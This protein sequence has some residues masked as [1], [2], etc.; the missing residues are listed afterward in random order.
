MRSAAQ[1]FSGVCSD[2]APASH[3]R[4]LRTDIQ[5]LRAISVLAVVLAHAKLPG[6]S[7]G[8]VGVDIF[9][10][11]SGFLITRLLLLEIA[12]TGR[13]D[14][15]RFWVK[16]A[17]R[18]LPNALT[19]LAVTA[20][21]AALVFP[22]Y[23][24]GQL[25]QEITLAAL[26]VVNFYFASTATD[27]FNFDG[28][29]SP[30][31]HFWSLNVE[32]QFYFAWPLILLFI[33]TRFRHKTF[34][35]IA[36]FLITL[37]FV[38]FFASLYI[39]GTDQPRAYFH[40]EMRCWQLAS[41][42]LLAVFS[43][44]I[45]IWPRLLR[46]A[47]AWAGFAAVLFSIASFHEAMTYPG[48]WALVPTLGTV[49]IL[50]GRIGAHSLDDPLQ[51]LFSLP[52]LQWI[53][54]RSYSWYLWHWPLLVLPQAAYP[55]MVYLPALSIL[56]S[57][58]VASLVYQWIEQPIRHGQ[59]RTLPART[60]AAAALAGITGTVGL[61]YAA[62]PAQRILNDEVALRLERLE[63]ASKAPRIYKDRCNLGPKRVDQPDCVYGDVNAF[64]QVVLF[65][66]SHAAQW[67]SPIEAAAIQTGWRLRSWTKSACPFVNIPLLY[68]N[69]TY[70]QCHTW[71][72]NVLNEIIKM[73][74]SAVIL[75][76]SMHYQNKAY[77]IETGL[78]INE[79][80]FYTTWLKHMREVIEKIARE[81]IRVIVIRDNPEAR[82][83]FRS[84]VAYGR[85][86]D[87]KRSD[88]FNTT[89][90]E[91]D[92]VQEMFPKARLM[93]FSDQICTSTTCPVM[94]DNIVVYSDKSHISNV[95]A[96]TFT[97]AF[98][99]LLTS[100]KNEPAIP[101]RQT[102]PSQ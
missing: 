81:G 95:F 77:D 91:F 58:V 16:R 92:A 62:I 24:L 51:R 75:A 71:Q 29:P 9:F 68:K 39:V 20:F 54:A 66:D 69:N 80:N 13:I 27:Y 85:S 6:F 78:V 48:T 70:D 10:V 89:Q 8:F 14:L 1:P 98:V 96:L 101:D 33:S 43:A 59:I 49:G 31:L 40:T 45:A 47:L 11:I 5:G 67:F 38:S 2:S 35:Y 82:E 30:V 50:A 63:A 42:A 83:D 23:Y 21:L 60:V 93:D 86:C 32:E 87:Q 55:E 25:A 56:L 4:E 28:T 44:K 76:S 26:E 15:K 36:F 72:T 102:P 57:L 22:G 90:P 19:T 97:P 18:L 73:R 12:A 88:A 7:G 46:R 79:Q 84:C 74:P 3:Q 100:L 34:T 17:L 64:E 53:G 65:G 52:A 61:G 37:W 41:G 94:K 99:Q